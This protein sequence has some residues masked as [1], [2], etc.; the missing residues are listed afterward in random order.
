MFREGFEPPPKVV[1]ASK[2]TL[3]G[4]QMAETT[5]LD[6]LTK[7]LRRRI[8]GLVAFSSLLAALSAAPRSAEAQEYSDPIEAVAADAVRE[9]ERLQELLETARR[10]VPDSESRLETPAGYEVL[11]E[12]HRGHSVRGTNLDSVSGSEDFKDWLTG[13]VYITTS[14]AQYGYAQ[15]QKD[16]TGVENISREEALDSHRRLMQPPETIELRGIGDRVR[17][18]AIGSTRAGAVLNAIGEAALYVECHV[19]SELHMLKESEVT[20]RERI[21]GGVEKRAREAGSV[22]GRLSFDSNSASRH[23]TNV[24]VI[25]ERPYQG[26]DGRNYFEVQIEATPAEVIQQE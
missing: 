1:E 8:G 3:T 17:A 26:A 2:E 15:I 12:R 23:F 6:S 20:T 21:V 14:F 4:L 25:S 7:R 22:E 24:R 16:A 19:R 9:R 10:E 18:S 13:P 5:W 11:Y